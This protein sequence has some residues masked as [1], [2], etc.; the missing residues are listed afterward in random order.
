MCLQGDEGGKVAGQIK[1][2]GCLGFPVREGLF[3]ALTAG[4]CPMG[5]FCSFDVLNEIG[6]ELRIRALE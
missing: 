3:M 5:G 2:Q 6:R 4:T 1:D